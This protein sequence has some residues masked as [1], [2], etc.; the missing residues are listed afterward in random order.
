MIVLDVCCGPQKIYEGLAGRLGNDFLTMDIRQVDETLHYAS[1]YTPIRININ[2]NVLA[3]MVR[4]PL[5]DKTVSVLICDPPH[6]HFGLSS[7]M[8]K[9][10]GSWTEKETVEVMAKANGEFGRILTDNGVLI[11]KIMRER[12]DLFFKT[13]T[14]FRFF[15]AIPTVKRIGCHDAKEGAVWHIAVKR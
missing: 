15:L 7:F 14:K 11:L 3:S 6:L 2:P 8:A 12:E 10:Y 5:A 4:I 1:R 9:Q 13:L